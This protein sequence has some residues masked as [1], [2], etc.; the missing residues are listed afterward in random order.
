MKILF[1]EA[2]SDFGNY[3]FPYAIWAFPEPKERP[4]DLFE[5]GFLPG[6]KDLDRFYL[7]RNVRID[8]SKF[9]PSSE[10]RRILRKGQ[11]IRLQLL[12]R[13]QFRYTEQRREFYKTYADIKFGKDVMPS[14]RLDALFHGKIVTHILLFIDEET[15]AEV[16]AVTLYVERPRMA[17]YYFAFYDLNYYPRSLGLYMMTSAVDFFAHR[18]FK[19][20]YLGTIY[21]RNAMYKTQFSGV[22]FF[23]GFEWASDLNQ[24]KHLI[25]R[26]GRVRD[27]HLLESEDFLS[28]FYDGSVK[29][30]SSSGGLICE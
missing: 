25:H 16:G 22:E 8:L 28:R 12:P 30:A 1:S 13:N 21:N 29:K 4:S 5:R 26:D 15:D 19:H 3:V 17:Y 18:R 6:T 14:E 9:K 2:K 10:N 7:C 20:L 24:L 27:H 11:G 23:N